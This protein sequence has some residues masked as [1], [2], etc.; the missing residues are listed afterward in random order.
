MKK[1]LFIMRHSKADRDEDRWED[2][3]RPLTERGRR[4]AAT[5][6]KWIAEQKFQIDHLMT[7]PAV[8]TQ[9]TARIVAEQI[10]FA[11]KLDAPPS[12]YEG[13]SKEYLT[14]IGLCPVT[15]GSLLL[16]GHNP[17]L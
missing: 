4:D 10:G 17:A 15:V 14:Q 6:V 8:R 1:Q 9:E 12:L 3:D 5:M 13:S 16:I 11:G 7:S 2:F